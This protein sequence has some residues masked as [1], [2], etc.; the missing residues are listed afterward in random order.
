MLK[1]VI[2]NESGRILVWTLVILALGTLLIP[3]LLARV[4]AN[5][6]ASRAI[7]EGLKEQYAADSGVEYAMLQLQSGITTSPSPIPTPYTINNKYV[8]VTWGEC[9]GITDTY[10]I[11]ST[12]T[13]QIDGSSTT[14]ES[15]ISLGMLNYLWLLDNAI[16]GADDVELGSNSEVYGDVMYGDDI[17]GEDN[18]QPPWSATYDPDIEDRWPTAARL[19][20][21]YWDD[22]EGLDADPGGYIDLNGTSSIGPFHRDGDLSIDNT[23]SATT[24]VLEGTVYVTGDLTFQQPGA[25]SAYT[26]D[27]NGQTIYVEGSIYFAPNHITI[28]GSGCIIAKGDVTF[29]PG[30]DSGPDDFVFVMSIEGTVQMQPNGDFYGSVA[31]DT[32]VDL[33]PNNTLTWREPPAGLNFPDGTT[34]SAQIRTYRVYP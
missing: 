34:G 20:E 25:S 28:S 4:S 5:L 12:A 21:F 22:V 16:T 18:I 11:T 33:Q 10:K 7:E 32:E 3:P 15:Y 8:E 13:S 1:K 19:S 29:Q 31:G 27:L 23:G 6:I 30:I 17:E 26:I 2:S 24:A 14:I 9:P